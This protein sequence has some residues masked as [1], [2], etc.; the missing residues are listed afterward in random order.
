MVKSP[1]EGSTAALIRLESPVTFSDFVRPICLPDDGK[2]YLLEGTNRRMDVA[3]E[4]NEPRAD[5]FEAA[6]PSQKTPRKINENTQYFIA[7]QSDDESEDTEKNFEKLISSDLGESFY[8]MPKAE[9]VKFNATEELHAAPQKVTMHKD[10][11]PWTN[12]NT[13]GWSRQRDHLQRVQLK[14]GDMGACENIS[15]ATVNSICTEA[16]FH[17]MDCTVSD[18]GC[19]EICFNFFSF[20]R[21]KNLPVVRWSACFPT[22]NVGQLWLSHRGE[23][24]VR[25]L[26]S[27][28][29]G[30]M[31][32][33]RPIPS[34]YG[35][36]LVQGLKPDLCAHTNF[37]GYP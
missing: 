31:T 32:R 4:H 8:E 33:F 20:N 1:V 37:D 23:S 2:R 29:Q 25:H 6:P 34:G 15:I 11:I 28:G 14:I 22:P 13:L 3:E 9:A 24:H 5:K 27:N 26:V 18:D 16:V 10:I 36:S 19:S 35:I 17:K 30:C 12:C 7:P 21:R